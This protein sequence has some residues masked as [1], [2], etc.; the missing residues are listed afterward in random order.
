[1][2]FFNRMLASVGIGAA[3]VDTQLDSSSVRIGEAVSGRVVVRAGN[4][5][6]TIEHINLYVVTR[7][8]HD[9]TY[10]KHVVQTERVVGRLDLKPGDTREVPFRFQLSHEAPLSLSGTSVWIETGAAISAAADPGDTDALTVLPNAA[11]EVLLEA[12]RHLGL[13]LRRAEMERGHG[14]RVIQELEFQPPYG[15]GLNEVEMVLFP[16][17]DRV[18]VILEV[19]RRA[20]GMAALFVEEFE[21]RSRWSITPDMVYAGPAA[22]ARELEARIHHT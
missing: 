4:V 5:A 21:S 22:L 16:Q 17:A 9:D 20:R 12:A 6:Q 1:M 15:W 2:S 19:D 13:N 7:Y 10:H 8:K 18:D 3:K 11:V 14:H